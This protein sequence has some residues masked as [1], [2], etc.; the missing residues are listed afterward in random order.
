MEFL[1]RGLSCLPC[2]IFRWNRCSVFSVSPNF[3]NLLYLLASHPNSSV[4]SP[5]VVGNTFTQA[6]PDWREG[7]Y[8]NFKEWAAR[9]FGVKD[10]EPG[11]EMDLPVQMKKARD[12]EFKTNKKGHYILPSRSDYKRT[13]EKQRV[14]RGYIG[15]V[16]RALFQYLTL[17]SF[18]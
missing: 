10:L 8:D 7:T 9:Q 1:K 6:C 4:E 5:P 11:D 16:Y 3:F 2:G 12:I 13:K 18:S 17:L 14:I 15:A